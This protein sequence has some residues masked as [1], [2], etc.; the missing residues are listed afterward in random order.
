MSKFVPW[1]S[2]P[3]EEWSKRYAPGKFIT[4]SGHQT[5]YIEKGEGEPIILLHGFGSDSYSW[6]NNI[7]VLAKHF[8]AYAVDLWGCGYSTRE[9]L[10][11][12]YPLYAHQV[13]LFMDA[14]NIPKASLIGQSMGGGTIIKLATE[15]R[16]RVKS[17]ILVCVGGMPQKPILAQ[18][19][20]ALPGLGE[21]ALSLPTDFLR[22][23]IIK[24]VY[25][26]QKKVTP[27][28]FRGLTWSQ[29]IEGSNATYLKIARLK[30][31]H[32]LGD[33]IHRLGEMEVPAL[34]IWGRHD[35]GISLRLSEEMHRIIK[36][37]RLEVFEHS[38]HEPHDE[39]PEKFNQIALDFL[40]KQE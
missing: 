36:G 9:L 10:D 32:T 30:F 8:K 23:M 15:H 22:K 11:F 31:F 38:G 4:L 24:K 19:L 13:Q 21:L 6:N 17:I 12:G 7:D 16:D 37:S 29:K 25:L 20:L 34:I 3:L 26:Y 14:L 1:N 40:T 35:K 5:H 27:E 39:E 33:E 2:Q 18:R 28:Y